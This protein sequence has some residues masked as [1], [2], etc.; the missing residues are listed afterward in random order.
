MEGL[1][2]PWEEVLLSLMGAA[3]IKVDT[4]LLSSFELSLNDLEFEIF[5]YPSLLE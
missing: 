2:Y 5:V 3:V 1:L 4:P